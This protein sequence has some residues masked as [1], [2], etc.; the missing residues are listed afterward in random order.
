MENA[1]YPLSN[2]LAL[3]LIVEHFLLSTPISAQNSWSPVQNLGNFGIWNILLCGLFGP[4]PTGVLAR[5]I[6]LYGHRFS[7]IRR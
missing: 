7:K 1:L 4:I 5:S 3:I 6:A 2:G